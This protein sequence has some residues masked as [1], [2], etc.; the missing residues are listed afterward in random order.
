[1][2]LLFMH[3]KC[4]N[5][6]LIVN[7]NQAEFID[8]AF[9]IMLNDFYPRLARGCWKGIHG[10]RLHR[11]NRKHAIPLY[12]SIRRGKSRVNENRFNVPRARARDVDNAPLRNTR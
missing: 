5:N 6:S 10:G 4:I 3:V 8:Q 11:K 12:D 1:M 7:N 9:Y 2:Y